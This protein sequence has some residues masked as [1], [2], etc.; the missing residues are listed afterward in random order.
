M[1]F[2]KICTLLFCVLTYAGVSLANSEEFGNGSNA[3]YFLAAEDV[4][5]KM[6][7]PEIQKNIITVSNGT[8]AQKIEMHK[9][10]FL[11]SSS[12]LSAREA[13]IMAEKC[14]EVWNKVYFKRISYD[15]IKYKMIENIKKKITVEDLVVAKEALALSG[16]VRPSDA[17]VKVI[18]S[19]RDIVRDTTMNEAEFVQAEYKLEIDKL[20]KKSSA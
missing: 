5:K 9:N 17:A 11:A 18:Y 16:V 13:E 12:K 1:N 10:K 7:I 15:L 19:V 6:K 3:E 8:N 14:V 4:L 20:G 2:V